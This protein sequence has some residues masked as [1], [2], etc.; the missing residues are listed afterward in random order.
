[1]SRQEAVMAVRIRKSVWSLPQGD[2]TFVWY[3]RAVAETLTRPTLMAASGAAHHRCAGI[4]FVSGHAQ[5]FLR[6]DF[7]SAARASAVGL[8]QGA[9]GHPRR[10]R[11][12]NRFDAQRGSRLS[13]R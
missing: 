8:L 13:L 5:G 10:L 11:L 7:V 12:Q 2:P 1:M 3:R 6:R 4:E 9:A